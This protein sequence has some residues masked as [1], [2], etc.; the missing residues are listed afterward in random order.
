MANKIRELRTSLS[1]TQSELAAQLGLNQS[2]IGKYERG[3]LEPNVDILKKLSAFFQCSID[4]IVE[5][6]DDFGVISIS[7]Q[8]NPT[9]DLT[10]E[11]KHLLETFRK[12]SMKNRIHVS[13]YADIRLEEQDVSTRKA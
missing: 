8:K 2:A 9:S 10:S 4:Y 5:N 1:L 7:T 6:S 12:L 11:E 13:A 3:E